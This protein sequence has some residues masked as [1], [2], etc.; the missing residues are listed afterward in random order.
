MNKNAY[1]LL[2]KDPPSI[3][4]SQ[5]SIFMFVSK[6]EANL[7]CGIS[8]QDHLGVTNF[9]AEVYI[10]NCCNRIVGDLPVVWKIYYSLYLN[11][12][13]RL[14]KVSEKCINRLAS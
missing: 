14:F 2:N 5:F 3:I 7:L 10:S 6:K 1:F 9:L 13:E 12:I 11:A 8:S 4:K